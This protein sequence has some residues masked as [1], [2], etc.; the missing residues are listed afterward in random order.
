MSYELLAKF[1]SLDEDEECLSFAFSA[2]E[3]GALEN[4]DVPVRFETGD[5]R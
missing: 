3:L 1:A 5:A 4:I 2:D